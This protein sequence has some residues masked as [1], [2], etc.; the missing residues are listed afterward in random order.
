[1]NEC[2]HNSGFSEEPTMFNLA[3]SAYIIRCSKCGVAVGILPENHKSQITLIKGD[4]ANILGKIENI[5]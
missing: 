1:M 3:G 2:K 4:V 5:K